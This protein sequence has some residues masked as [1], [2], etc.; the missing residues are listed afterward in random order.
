V[1]LETLI[2]PFTQST[3]IRGMVGNLRR[4]RNGQDFCTKKPQMDTLAGSF[5]ENVRSAPEVS[6][7]VLMVFADTDTPITYNPEK[8]IDIPGAPPRIA[9]R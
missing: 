6:D 5:V 2:V 9:P 3:P 1:P 4:V 7:Q 8:C